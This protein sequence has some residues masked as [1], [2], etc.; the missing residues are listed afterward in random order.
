[1]RYRRLIQAHTLIGPARGEREA[2]QIYLG[3]IKEVIEIGQVGPGLSI[4][5]T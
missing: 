3:K 4:S 5:S 2:L 1:M